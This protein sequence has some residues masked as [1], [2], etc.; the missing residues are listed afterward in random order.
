[1]G[2]KGGGRVRMKQMGPKGPPMSSLQDLMGPQE[3]MIQHPLKMDSNIAYFV[4]VTEAFRMSNYKTSA[5]ACIWPTYI[6]SNKTTKEGRRI[7]KADAVDNPSVQDISEVLES[8]GVRHVLQPYKGYPRDVESRW[9][10]LGRV[11]YDLERAQ[12]LKKMVPN[13]QIGHD[14]D[15]IPSLDDESDE[16][17]QKEIWR[18]IASQIE[19]MPGRKQRLLEAKQKEEEEKK[20][21]R[22]EARMKAVLQ[23]K[24]TN[25]TTGGSNKKKGKKRK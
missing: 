6:D 8:V 7:A 15:P 11:L 4:P 10:N 23:S 12:P 25:T 14:N 13:V 1:M 18:L 2:K 16:I 3:E 9:Y 24:K 22:D 5:F 17:T 21:V 19:G 20:R